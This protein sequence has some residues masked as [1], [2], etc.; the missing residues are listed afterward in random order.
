MSWGFRNQRL[1]KKEHP[2]G[3]EIPTLE[4]SDHNSDD[5]GPFGDY[6]RAK[7]MSAGVC[8]PV[9]EAATRAILKDATSGKLNTM[10]F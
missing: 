6:Q 2:R 7:P 8:R 10:R 9:E 5:Q 4:N 1:S 3:D